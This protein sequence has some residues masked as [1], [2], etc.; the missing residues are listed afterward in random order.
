ML[1]FYGCCRFIRDATVGTAKKKGGKL[2]PMVRSVAPI[3]FHVQGIC[4]RTAYCVLRT[5]YCVTKNIFVCCC[6]VG[7][8]RAAG[9]GVSLGARN[10]VRVGGR[11]C[12]GRCSHTISRLRLPDRQLDFSAP[13]RSFDGP[14]MLNGARLWAQASA[15]LDKGTAAWVVKPMS[16]L[17]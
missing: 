6:G 8:D 1:G 3:R 13:A 7:S 11:P 2:L 12:L 4:A 17:H 5:A 14:R 9:V 16:P 15:I 10:L